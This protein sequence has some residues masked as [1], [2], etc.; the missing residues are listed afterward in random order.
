MPADHTSKAST[1]AAWRFFNDKASTLKQVFS[2]I[3]AKVRSQIQSDCQQFV[4]VACDWCNLHYKDHHGKKG[5]VAL[6]RIQDLGYEMFSGLALND[7]DGQPIGP[8]WFELRDEQGV[9]STRCHEVRRAISVLD[10]VA[11]SMEF[12]ASLNLGPVPIFI[13]DAECDSIAHLRQ[14]DAAGMTF[15]VRGQAK[16]TA[17]HEN[18]RRNLK[19]IG[20][21]LHDSGGFTYVRKVNYEGRKLQQWVA[22]TA[23]IITRPARPERLGE[24][25]KSIPGVPLPLRL[26]VSELRDENGEVVATWYLYT[27]AP[28]SVASATIVLWYYWRW[29]IEDFHKLLKAAGQEME[30]WGQETCEA[31]ARRLAVATMACLIVWSLAR[32]P[33]E[34]AAQIRQVLVRLSGRQMSRKR[35]VTA[36][37]MFAGLW[38]LLAFDDAL[39]KYDLDALRQYAANVRNRIASIFL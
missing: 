15:L 6:S 12:A 9:H 13:I 34:E 16:N 20:D 21:V 10:E 26:I 36:P 22:E 30:H 14:W 18:K 27:N 39:R 35:P 25:R 4:P 8:L 24:P 33:G 29:Q 28:A 5:R 3:L 19:E 2:P 11:A 32:D 37:A 31:I 7:V 23:I 1:Q 38:V 17:K